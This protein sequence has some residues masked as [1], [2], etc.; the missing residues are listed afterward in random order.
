MGRRLREDHR[1]IFA[2]CP[3]DPRPG[4]ESGKAASGVGALPYHEGISQRL[5]RR[6]R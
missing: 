3:A 6:E 2:R 5:P 4:T 1:P